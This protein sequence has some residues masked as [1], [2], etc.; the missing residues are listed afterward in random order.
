MLHSLTAPVLVVFPRVGGIVLHTEHSF[1]LSLYMCLSE[2]FSSAISSYRAEL[3]LF[4]VIDTSAVQ[5]V[6][7]HHWII[8]ANEQEISHVTFLANCVYVMQ[9]NASGIVS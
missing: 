4:L 5:K 6:L 7:F 2:V 3:F 9:F 1:V 8:L